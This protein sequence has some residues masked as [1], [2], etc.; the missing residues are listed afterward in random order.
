VDQAISSVC[1]AAVALPTRG[2]VAA[3]FLALGAAMPGLLVL[4][5]A[6]YLGF[7][8][9]LVARAAML[10]IVWLVVQVGRHRRADSLRHGRPYFTDLAHS[11]GGLVGLVGR[12][13]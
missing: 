13:W 3:A 11:R 8:A 9:E 1:C 2:A 4:D 10:D 7:A 12:R 5:M 6:R